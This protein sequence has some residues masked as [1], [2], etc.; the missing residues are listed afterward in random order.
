MKK[1][2]FLTIIGLVLGTIVLLVG[3]AMGSSLIIFWD[4]P[5]V[6]ITVLGSFCAVLITYSLADVKLLGIIMIQTFKEVNICPEKLIEKFVEL[7]RKARKNGLLSLED[8]IENLE[9]EFLKKGLQMAIDGFE[10]ENIRDILELELNEMENRHLISANM[11]SC[12]GAYAPAFGM[13]G[14]LI[15]LIQMLTNLSDIA[16]IA[17][18]MGK[19]LITTFYGSL[20]ANLFCNPMAANLKNKN[21]KEL[22]TK[23][24][25]IEGILAMQAGVNP[26]L[27]EERLLAYL[28][29]KD[30]KKY[31]EKINLNKN[32]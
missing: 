19:A 2:D 29:P 24:M 14:T 20:L 27:M 8:D 31:I 12:W 18:G 7:S 3:M 5:S 4:L 23:D 25:I 1:S 32:K 16:N 26:K 15:G 9:D 10:P 6:L 22:T 21:S 11:L 13:I 28:S 30:K 17:S